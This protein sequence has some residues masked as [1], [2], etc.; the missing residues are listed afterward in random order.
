LSKRP[1]NVTHESEAPT[2]EGGEG[3]F[4]SVESFLGEAAGSVN[5]GLQRFV[6]EEGYQS[7]PEHYHMAEEEIF[8]VLKG[9]GTLLQDG[10]RVP[11]GPGDVIS[12]PAGTGVSHA[13]LA[14][15]G[16]RLEYLAF[17]QRNINDVIFYPRSKKVA[18]RS[19]DFLGRLGEGAGYFDGEPV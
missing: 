2:E 19:V 12:Y 11:V 4:R 10:E 9:K 14:D 5:V 6:V 1:P 3:R 17:G 7:L 13:F 16:E 8:Y 18:I 15:K